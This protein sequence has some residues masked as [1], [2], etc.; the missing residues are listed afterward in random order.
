MLIDLDAELRRFGIPRRGVIQIGAHEGQEVAAVAAMGF[1]AIHLVEANPDVFDRL[2]AAT[3]SLPDTTWA[4]VAITDRNGE[5]TLNVA[6]FDQSSSLLDLKHHRDIFPKI[7]VAKRITVAGRTL[8]EHLKAER[9]AAGDYNVLM[10]DTQGAEFSILRG[11]SAYLERCDA[12]LMEVNLAELYEG[13]AE[14]E[15]IDAYLFDRGFVRVRTGLWS[16]HWGDALYVR[17]TFVTDPYAILE[18]RRGLVQMRDLGRNG[19]FANQLFQLAFAYFYAL[20]A[21]ARIALPKWKAASL[22]EG[23]PAFEKP[24]NLPLLTF[25][26]GNRDPL[27]FW[28][29]ENPPR[30][31]DFSGYFQDFPNSWRI[32]HRDLFR[33][34]FRF[35]PDLEAALA[36]WRE[37]ATEGGRRPLI[38]L[39]VR[40]GD[41]VD[42]TP[43]S[44]IF[45]RIPFDWFVQA[46]RR[47]MAEHPTAYVHVS[48]DDAIVAGQIL[49]AAG[50]TAESEPA[51][52][53]PAFLRDFHALRTADAALL[54]NSSFSRMAALL[55]Q[56]GQRTL[57]V[58]PASGEFEPYDA[59]AE[60]AFWFRFS[61]PADRHR[62]SV[63][64]DCGTPAAVER[65]AAELV[66][67]ADRAWAARHPIAR[68]LRTTGATWA[69]IAGSVLAPLLPRRWRGEYLSVAAY[70]EQM[71]DVS[72]YWRVIKT[73]GAPAQL[74]HRRFIK[75]Q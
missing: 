61:S 21:G 10:M 40:R 9:L 74:P 24:M 25:A 27:G 59:W 29:I 37:E 49:T 15:T 72:E 60:D 13:C 48:S 16:R 42:A 17:S 66:A 38:A 30:D 44:H 55:A 22:F 6:D 7:D 3:A 64:D 1:R 34:L 35:R 58:N 51:C 33:R 47:L 68:W 52:D 20:R 70:R 50:L 62:K 8:D 56:H 19:Q 28:E 71:R 18:G 36:A 11:A 65:R 14:V 32:H 63:F 12:I 73:G 57:L 4:Q 2:T 23:L 67:A 69:A 54:G 43:G 46:L 75:D 45:S 5:V 41:Y 53:A 26:N 39:H 31:I